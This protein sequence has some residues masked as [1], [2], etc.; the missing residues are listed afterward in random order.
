VIVAAPKSEREILEWSVEVIVAD[1][2]EDIYVAYLIGDRQ[3]ESDRQRS[4][5]LR[6]LQEPLLRKRFRDYLRKLTLYSSPNQ[7][8][9]I[10]S[11]IEGNSI[12]V[13]S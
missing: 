5:M 1:E 9:H 11:F 10:E 8:L 6:Q 12:K 7:K 2:L 13:K 4:L 3:E